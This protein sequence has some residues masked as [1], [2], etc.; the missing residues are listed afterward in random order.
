MDTQSRAGF[1]LEAHFLSLVASADRCRNHLAEADSVKARN[2]QSN[3]TRFL[4]YAVPEG[5]IGATLSDCHLPAISKNS[6]RY[7]SRGNPVGTF[8]FYSDAVLERPSRFALA[9]TTPSAI[10]IYIPLPV[11]SRDSYQ[12]IKL[13]GA[14][15]EGTH[16]QAAHYE[17]LGHNCHQPRPA[18][19]EQLAGERCSPKKM[20]V[21][22]G[23]VHNFTSKH[24]D[25]PSVTW[26]VRKERR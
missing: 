8:I 5:C 25:W 16:Q 12:F 10:A 3:S 4:S 18:A 13:T 14:T 2:T 11:F 24:R 22:L 7:A 23:D 9:A 15:G 21:G 17:H 19:I 6:D 20:K 1:L 26:A